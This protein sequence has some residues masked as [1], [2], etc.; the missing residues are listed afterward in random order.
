M[1]NNYSARDV[2][3]QKLQGLCSFCEAVK[4]C[5]LI[6]STEPPLLECEE[7]RTASQ[8]EKTETGAINAPDT[9]SGESLPFVH[10]N[11]TDWGQKGLCGNCAILDTCPFSKDEGGVW[12]CEEYR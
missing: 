11:H 10:S 1:K 7:F 5:T 4:R 12:R 2:T 9:M 6:Q 3:K 8:P